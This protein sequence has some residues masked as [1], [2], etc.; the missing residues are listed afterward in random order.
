MESFKVNV[1]ATSYA[2]HL[3]LDNLVNMG[4]RMLVMNASYSALQINSLNPLPLSILQVQIFMVVFEGVAVAAAELAQ[5]RWHATVVGYNRLAKGKLL[6][7]NGGWHDGLDAGV[8]MVRCSLNWVHS[9]GE[10]RRPA[11]K[12]A[13]LRGSRVVRWVRCELT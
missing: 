2:L 10:G 8:S 1:N 3:D 4:I 9:S 11:M 12:M 5:L 7:V 13:A 6:M